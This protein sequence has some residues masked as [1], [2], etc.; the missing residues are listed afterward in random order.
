MAVVIKVVMAHSD[1]HRV[2]NFGEDLYRLFRNRNDASM[3]LEQIDDI[4]YFVTVKGRRR[5]R[6]ITRKIHELLIEHN[7][8]AN[9]S[10]ADG[11]EVRGDGR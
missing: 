7:L 8:M 10:L 3:P 9:L 4:Q 11:E 2:R 6:Q 5:V 1:I